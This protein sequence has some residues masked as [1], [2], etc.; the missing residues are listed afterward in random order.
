MG[1]ITVYRAPS[2]LPEYNDIEGMAKYWKTYYNT[3]QGAG[4][5]ERAVQVMEQ[6][7]DL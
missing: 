6:V 5:L 4:T 1:A 2:A 3:S 7:K